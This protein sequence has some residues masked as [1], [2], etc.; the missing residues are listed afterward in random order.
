M[1]H[2]IF[3]KN[4]S[5]LTSFGKIYGQTDGVKIGEAFDGERIEITQSSRDGTGGLYV[6]STAHGTV[7]YFYSVCI[8]TRVVYNYSVLRLECVTF[9]FWCIQY[10]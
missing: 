8:C 10:Y 9:N 3:L 7:Q 1:K 4:D 5:Y 2:S 6:A